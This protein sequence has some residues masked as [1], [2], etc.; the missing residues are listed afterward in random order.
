MLRGAA[1]VCGAALFAVASCPAQAQMRVNPAEQADYWSVN[2]SLP[3]QYADR[4]K[5][6]AKSSDRSRSAA[7]SERTP[8]DRVPLRNAPGGSVGFT[9]GQSAS[10]GR[11]NDG[12]EVPGLNPNTQKESSYVGMS[13]SVSSNSKGLPIPVPVPTPWNRTE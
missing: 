4:P 10:S 13:L 8:I 6:P 9:A 3:S 12:R 11:F 5:Q 2:T 7:P 1:T